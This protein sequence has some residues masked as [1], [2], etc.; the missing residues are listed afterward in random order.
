MARHPALLYRSLLLLLAS[1]IAGFLTNSVCYLSLSHSLYLSLYL[2]I[3][4]S[5][6]HSLSL[7]SSLSLCPSPCFDEST[8]DLSPVHGFHPSAESRNRRLAISLS[9]GHTTADKIDKNRPILKGLCHE[10]FRHRF[11]AIFPL[12][13]A[14]DLLGIKPVEVPL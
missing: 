6:T 9:L 5:L 1:H 14:M 7:S 4:L 3:Y 2:S 11:K 12:S 10:I 13:R 8:Q